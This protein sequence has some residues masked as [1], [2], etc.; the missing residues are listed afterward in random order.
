[1]TVYDDL[2][3]ELRAM[4]ASLDRI[5]AVVAGEQTRE[6][7]LPLWACGH[8]HA[9]PKEATDCLLSRVEG[10][11]RRSGESDHPIQVNEA[12]G[13]IPPNAA[14]GTFG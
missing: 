10:I 12:D 2:L 7:L 5:A 4:R 9:S 11:W 13:L 1:M 14:A 3:T 6:E 8:R